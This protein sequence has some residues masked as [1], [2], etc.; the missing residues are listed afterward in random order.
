[1]KKIDIA[2]FI[3]VCALAAGLARASRAQSAG[4]PLPQD[5]HTSIPTAAGSRPSASVSRRNSPKV[6]SAVWSGG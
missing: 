4:V 3:A 2:K 5:V 6:S 1:M